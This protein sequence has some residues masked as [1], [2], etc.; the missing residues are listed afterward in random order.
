L[1]LSYK[2]AGFL[3]LYSNGNPW[4]PERPENRRAKRA[5]IGLGAATGMVIFGV[6]TGADWPANIIMAIVGG[7]LIGGLVWAGV[8]N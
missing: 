1:T 7:F 6:S 8:S 4:K 3:M 2:Q 5:A